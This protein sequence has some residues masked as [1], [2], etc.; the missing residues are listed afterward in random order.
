[1]NSLFNLLQPLDPV[2]HNLFIHMIFL[3]VVSLEPRCSTVNGACASIVILSVHFFRLFFS[4]IIL[5]HGKADGKVKTLRKNLYL[6]YFDCQLILF[7]FEKCFEL[8]ISLDV[9]RLSRERV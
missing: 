2:Q 8:E 6:R 5:V 7:L 9:L 3:S 4:L 1:M